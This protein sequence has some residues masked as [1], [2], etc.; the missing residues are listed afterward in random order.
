MTYFFAFNADEFTLYL[1]RVRRQISNC[2]ALGVY[3]QDLRFVK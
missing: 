2:F 1:R 3:S